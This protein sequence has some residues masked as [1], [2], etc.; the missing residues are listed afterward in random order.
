MLAWGRGPDQ[1]LITALPLDAS[2]QPAGLPLAHF[3]V[4]EA[5]D[6]RALW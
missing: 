5:A 6:N 4:S 2:S 3:W 1:I